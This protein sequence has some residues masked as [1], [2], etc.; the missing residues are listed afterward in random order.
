MR[1]KFTF[2]LTLLMLI[3]TQFSFAQ[4]RTI[5]G[6][7]TDGGGAVP[8]VN[9]IVK[10]TKNGTQTDFDGKYSVKAKTGDVLIFSY[11]GMQDFTA[12]VG[13]SSVVN[14]K[15]QEAGKELQEVVVVGYGVQ[16]K[17]EVTGSI[18]KI[19]GNE[20]ANI[21]T[22]SFEGAL[23]GRATGVQIVTNSGIIGVA[24]KIRIR[25]IASISGGTEPLIVV[26]GMPI[27]SGDIGGVANTNGLA[28]I[29]PADIE[30]YEVLKDGAS[31]A[32]YGSRAAN[33]VILITTKSGKK[34]TMKVNFSSTLGIASAAKKYDLLQTPDF[35]VISNEKRTNAGQSPWAIGDTYNTD[36]QS[37]ILRNAPQLTHN[38]SFSGGS[39]KTKYYLSL[40]LTDQDGIN[41]GNNM[42]RYSIRANI[43]QD[44]NRWL[45]IGTNL[46]VTRTEYNGLNTNA[47]GLSGNIFNAIRQ[48]PNVPI[49]D[50]NNP[51]GYNLS[52]DNTTV[53]KWD[54]TDPVGDNIT[55]IVYVL[56]HNRYYSKVNRTLANIFANAKITSDLTYR[57]Q[58]SADNA[59]TDGF[60]YWNPIHGDGRTSNGILY[61]DNTEYLRWNWQNILNYKK[62]FAENHNI[63]VTLVSEYQKQTYKNFWGE[64]TDL[65]SD[66]Y[67]K[68]LVD[69]SY[70]TKDSGGSVT[71]N[72]IISYLGRF[73]YNFKEKYFI[74]ASIRRDGISKLDPDTRWTNFPG[75]SAGWTISK[76]EF[77]QPLSSVITDLKLRGSYS[78]VG[79]TDILNGANYPYLGLTISS[80]Y[81]KLNG[82]G[83]YQFGND[84][85]QW[86]SSA[87]S[88]F[89]VDLGLLNNRLTIAF[90][91]YRN[92]ID[93]LILAAP[94]APSLGVPNNTIN[95]NIGKL[96]N[97]GY[98]FAVSFKAFKNEKF[99][100]DLSSNL[101]LSKNVVTNVYNGQD[102]IGGSSTDTNIAPNIIIREGESLNSLYGFRYWGVNK[103]NGNP[104]YY[105]ADGSLVQGLIG[106][107]TYAV[108]DPAD[109][110]NTSTPSS[111]NSATDKVI[112][113]KT[114][115]TYYGSFTSSMKYKNLD[116]GFMFRFSGGNKIFNGTRRELMNQNFNNN[117]TEILG[118]WQS[119]E[120][121]GD[122]WTPRLYAS[123]NTFTNLSG[124]ASSRFVESGNFISLDNITFGYTLPKELMDRIKVDNF[125]FF[126]QAQNIWLITKYKGLN[127]EMETSGVDIN[128]TPRTKVMS[129]GINVSL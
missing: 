70:S 18:S 124:S 13:T 107:S 86:E 111:L 23:A 3:C 22:P 113:G 39:D 90:D 2:I 25:G 115:P 21:V 75:V 9:V 28:D 61:N 57:L 38:V 17:K 84:K 109:P 65:M 19:S 81:A 32:I 56:D 117:S 27:V 1:L 54:N 103:A 110:T 62:T 35:L 126:V 97:Q 15:L 129:M 24:P 87:K 20:I 80:P 114:L 26:D 94:T 92:N 106:Q 102:I 30:S 88:D 42:K 118:R 119:V 99:T 73:T 71:E 45:S 125:R 37:A 11:M 46:S 49:Y 120:N 122:G 66:F 5:S 48:Q 40:G 91:Y 10:G 76:E 67:N 50:P 6:V 12:T 74:Q 79:N 7:V 98:E 101:T 121:P 8:G 44:I 108:F 52:E 36:W 78:K 47:S 72:G 59:I 4:E 69:N 123:S 14:A 33:G 51:T 96:Y 89:G 29:N 58:I 85:L 64:G 128:G 127:P 95:K 93:K 43:D 100:W 31:T 83:Y 77:M 104:V 105:K 53:G 63:G 41:K 112:L 60:Q 82:L 16:K 55:N 34:G 68:N 116:L